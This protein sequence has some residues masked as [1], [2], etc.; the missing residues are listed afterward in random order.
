MTEKKIKAVTA[1]VAKVK[2]AVKPKSTAPAARKPAA[3]GKKAEKKS[4][5]A[6]VAKKAM[7]VEIKP[8][9]VKEA[10]VKDDRKYLLSVGRRKSSVAQV[11]YYAE[12]NGKIGVNG[13]DFKV[14]FPYFELQNIVVAP[15]EL[16]GLG[17]TGDISVKVAGGGT[18]GQA[19]AI[20]LGIARVLLKIDP[21]LRKTLKPAGFLSRD[22]RE[23]ERKKYGL[24]RARRAPQ[25]S[26]R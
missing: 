9:I 13:R 23:K 18:R 19:E 26:K 6:A 2:K 17:K 21:E 8:E 11:R 10:I 15:L 1:K 24:K 7:P 5:V 25:F 4:S 22:A 20:R 12:G 16:S 3:G 14:Y